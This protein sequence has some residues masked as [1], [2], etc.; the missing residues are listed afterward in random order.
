MRILTNEE[1][2]LV[3]GGFSSG[4]ASSQDPGAYMVENY[5]DEEAPV[6]T[7]EPTPGLDQDPFFQSLGAHFATTEDADALAELFASASYTVGEVETVVTG[8]Y[9]GSGPAWGGLGEDFMFAMNMY[10]AF[11]DMASYHAPDPDVMAALDNAGINYSVGADGSIYAPGYGYAVADGTSFTPAA[12]IDGGTT[13]DPYGATNTVVILGHTNQTSLVDVPMFGDETITVTGQ[14]HQAALLPMAGDLLK[15]LFEHMLSEEILRWLHEEPD[16]SRQQTQNHLNQLEHN[17]NALFNPAQ[18]I[19]PVTLQM[20]N[21]SVI[22]GF[23]QNHI[24]FADV[25]GPNNVPNGIP[26]F[27]VTQNPTTGQYYI[28]YGNGF[29]PSGNPFTTHPSL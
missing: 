11:Q 22:S 20:R 5:Y 16:T 14:V 1:C 3:A 29:I 24:F 25:R 26:D 19:S 12:S 2:L 28:N 8:A 18:A 13:S 7:P 17:V 9:Q 23:T 10:A 4:S 27:A 15:G 21:G 6:P